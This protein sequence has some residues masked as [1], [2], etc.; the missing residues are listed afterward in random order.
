ML[1]CV[2]KSYTD[3]LNMIPFDFVIHILWHK[4]CYVENPTYHAISSWK[5]GEGGGYA[6][7]P[8]LMWTTA[9]FPGGAMGVTLKSY[10]PKKCVWLYT[11]S[12]HTIH[13]IYSWD[14]VIAINTLCGV[15]KWLLVIILLFF[16]FDPTNTQLNAIWVDSGVFNLDLWWLKR[17]L[18]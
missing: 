8:G 7:Y 6:W 5:G 9:I 1:H 2:G 16:L 12:F 10:V 13:A 18:D 14:K 17:W 11:C 15:N 3:P 4:K